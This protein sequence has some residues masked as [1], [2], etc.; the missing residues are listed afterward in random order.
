MNL[1]EI[2][3]YLEKEVK[4][5]IQIGKIVDGDG[6]GLFGTSGYTPIFYMDNTIIEYTGLQVISR[7]SSYVEGELNINKVFKLLNKL[8]GFKPEQSPFFIGRDEKDRADFSVNYTIT[9]E[10][11]I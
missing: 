10:G 4:I 2:K 7:N 3:K 6:I 1:L 9:K 5:P 11:T 8:E